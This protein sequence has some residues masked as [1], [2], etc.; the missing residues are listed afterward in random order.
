M[1][2]D[3]TSLIKRNT[4]E[5]FT[6]VTGVIGLLLS[7]SL[8]FAISLFISTQIEVVKDTKK[9]IELFVYPVDRFLPEPAE[10][11]QYLISMLVFPFSLFFI[12]LYLNKIKYNDF[13][14]KILKAVSV[15]T[16]LILGIII[17]MDIYYS[18]TNNIFQFVVNYRNIVVSLIVFVTSLMLIKTEIGNSLHLS[19]ILKYFNKGL[20]FLL[21]GMIFISNIYNSSYFYNKWSSVTNHFNATFYSVVQVYFGKAVL[22]DFPSQ[23]GLY[24][25]FLNPIF[26]ITGLT[27]ITFSI[28]M[29]ILL[30]ASYLFIYKV[31][32]ETVENK[33]LILVGYPFVIFYGYLLLRLVS[34]GPYFQ[35]NPVR[36][37]FPTLMIY[38]AHKYLKSKNQILYYLSFVI[39]SVAILWNLDTGI[40][41]FLAWIILLIYEELFNKDYY[42]V[43]KNSLKHIMTGLLF[44]V[45]IVTIY[46]YYTY[47]VYGNYP[48]FLNF[49]EYQKYFYIYG[50]YMLPMKLFEPWNLV[51]LTYMIGLS[52]S[53]MALIK[54]EGTVRVKMIFLLS[55]LGIGLFSYF[56]G[57]SHINVLT[58][59]WYPALIL[60]VIFTEDILKSSRRL[61][62]K[63]TY[64]II[65]AYLLFICSSGFAAL[66]T[67][68]N[69]I[70][71]TFT[72]YQ[73][74]S[75]TMIKSI[76]F[77]KEQVRNH[78]E[79][80]ILSHFSSVYYL[81]S[82]TTCPINIPGFTELLLREDYEKIESYLKS[83][84]G[85]KIFIDKSMINEEFMKRLN[86][87]YKED[88]ISSDGRLALFIKR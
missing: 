64:L 86:V 66:L 10:R 38:L 28:V 14:F 39:Y 33:V 7:V 85:N 44:I 17:W 61:P 32:E 72:N 19:A 75:G 82:Q 24:P 27:V 16:A 25:H 71:K 9:I 67:N 80:I 30:V 74:D 73:K 12:I 70:N 41:V 21:L 2:N 87:F 57:R 3:K 83:N 40:I 53:V 50:F 65:G 48:N 6:L 88:G 52:Y 56:Q 43:V 23:Y 79:I 84:S 15:G 77:V 58:V 31:L 13:T 63:T 20:A 54:R 4:D 51:I 42:T 46:A 8:V 36:L 5:E 68:S 55:I 60:L 45:G 62:C 49:F 76:N 78:E 47:I 59:V 1:I 37:I 11:L 29:G 18:K 81:E 26:K 35:Y 22:I 34:P 69:E